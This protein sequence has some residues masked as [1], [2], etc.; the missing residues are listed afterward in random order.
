MRRFWFVPL[1]V[2]MALVIALPAAADKLPKPP[3]PSTSA[4]VA[5]SLNAD[6]MWVHEAGDVIRY[7]V[8]VQNKSRDEVTVEI[9]WTEGTMPVTITEPRG[10]VAYDDLFSHTVTAADVAADIDIVGSVKVTYDGGEVTAETSTVMDPIDPCNFDALIGGAA[11]IWKPP[12]TGEWTVSFTPS[13][14]QEDPPPNKPTRMMLTM[15]DGVPGNWCTLENGEGGIV[16]ERWLP[17][18]STSIDLYV[19]LPD[20]DGECLLGGHGVC[21]EPDCYFVVGNP[22]SFYL[23]TSFN[24]TATLTQNL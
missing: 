23:Y 5:V 22:L 8:T 4:P 17:K 20:G 6:P 19:Y 13:F 12:T 7:D 3:K 9:E 1:T 10:V 24:G 15:R 18:S 2:A 11:C 21:T 16:E 14:T